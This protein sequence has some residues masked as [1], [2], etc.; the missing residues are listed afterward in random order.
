LRENL[1]AAN[2]LLLQEIMPIRQVRYS[3]DAVP[4][5]VRPVCGGS[6][7]SVREILD[8][9]RERRAIDPL[10]IVAIGGGNGLS[11]LLHGLK[12]LIFGR[13]GRTVDIDL[14][15]VVTVTDDG[16]SSGRLRRE[17]DVLP[18]GDIRNCMVAMSEDEALLSRLFQYRFESGRGLKGHSFGNLFLTALTH[19]TGDF[20]KAVQLSS[21]VLASCGRIYP[22]TAA[23]V[24]LE[25]ELANGEV[26]TG[27]TRISRTRPR[28]VKVRLRPGDADPHPETLEAIAA[29]DLVVLG[30]GSLF[31]SV[32]P[33]VLVNGIPAAI[34]NSKAAKAY[35]V[36]LM[37]Q[38][39]ETNDFTASDHVR[40]I[41][42]HAGM[43]LIDVAIM[44]TRPITATLK[45]R[46]AAEKARPVENDTAALLKM[47]VEVMEAELAAGSE[48]I[49][50]DPAATADIVVE[51]ARRGHYS[52]T[53]RCV[54]A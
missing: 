24:I 39:G 42:Q 30:P 33:N 2:A 46:Y 1:A 7:H 37:W 15:A 9:M 32:I 21:E 12:D 10:R 26:V 47:G 45:T 52:R 36:N 35:F 19:L 16:G 6:L 38:P 4:G 28:I 20:A 22:S 48:K 25:A 41:H 5:P 23:N 43:S 17:L 8:L 40:A 44:N 49:R 54:S 29:A 27:E 3:T 13:H 51:L 14:T 11:A 50:H 34:R 31:T 53:R 18:P